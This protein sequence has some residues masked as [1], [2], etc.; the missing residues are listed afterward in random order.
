MKKAQGLSLGYV[1]V[2][3]IAVV[4]LVVVILIFTGGMQPLNQQ[5]QDLTNKKCEDVGGTWEVSCPEGQKQAMGAFA[6]YKENIGK[7]CCVADNSGDSK[8]PAEGTQ[9]KE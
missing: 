2:G 1:V 8:P 5:A 9:P 6:D 3:I 4:V 7:V